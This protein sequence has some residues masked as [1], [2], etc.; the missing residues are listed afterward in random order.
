MREQPAVVYPASVVGSFAARA[1]ME[2]ASPLRQS[3]QAAGVRLPAELSASNGVGVPRGAMMGD[4]SL[5]KGG[6]VIN[7]SGDSGRHRVR[8]A[9]HLFL[10]A[11]HDPGIRFGIAQRRKADARQFVGQRTGRL[12]VVAAR[13]HSQRPLPQVIQLSS[14]S[15][16]DAGRAQYR[17]GTMGEQHAQVAVATLAENSGKQGTDHD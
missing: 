7:K 1:D 14:C 4:H 17:A 12:V 9:F 2:S 16:R 3:V 5:C 11:R 13:L 8:G 10:H 15:L 6:R